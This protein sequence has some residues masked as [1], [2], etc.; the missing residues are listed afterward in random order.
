MYSF[1]FWGCGLRGVG[2]YGGHAKCPVHVPPSPP[3]TDSRPPV[4]GQAQNPLEHGKLD[5]D[6]NLGQSGITG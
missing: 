1:G 6:A 5:T 2:Y 4:T 3:P